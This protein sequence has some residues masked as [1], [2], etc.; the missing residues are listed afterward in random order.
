MKSKYLDGN[1]GVAQ[2]QKRLLS[3]GGV[4]R[5]SAVAESL[6]DISVSKQEFTEGLK[7]LSYL[8]RAQKERPAAAL[9]LVLF[10]AKPMK[11]INQIRR[12]GMFRASKYEFESATLRAC[13]SC[14]AETQICTDRDSYPAIYIQSVDNLLSLTRAV[15]AVHLS[16]KKE[17]ANRSK[18]ALKSILLL[19]DMAL[20]QYEDYDAEYCLADEIPERVIEAASYLLNLIKGPN[21]FRPA[22]VFDIDDNV[23]EKGNIYE[24]LVRSAMRVVDYR[25]AETLLDGLPYHARANGSTVIVAALDADIEKSVRVGYTQH[26]VQKLIRIGAWSGQDSHSKGITLKEFVNKTFAGG[27]ENLM[28]LHSVPKERIVFAIPAETEAFSF[29]FQEVG[30]FS[31][32]VLG[33]LVLEVDHWGKAVGEAIKVSDNLDSFDIFKVQ[34]IFRLVHYV[35]H[36]KLSTIADPARRRRLTARSAIPVLKREQ[37]LALMELAIP[38]KS[39]ECLDLLSLTNDRLYVD[40]QYTPFVRVGGGYLI[41]PFIVAGSNLVRNVVYINRLHD[42]VKPPEDPMTRLVAEHLKRREF[43]VVSELERKIDGKLVEF[44]ILAYREG[45]ML[46]FECKNSFFPCS[47]HEMRTSWDHVESAARQLSERCALLGNAAYQKLVVSSLGWHGVSVSQLY[48]AIIT[49]N[50]IFHG[51][52]IEGH[53]VRQARELI[54]VLDKGEIRLGDEVRRLWRSSTFSVEDLVIYL[55]DQNSIARAQLGAMEMYRRRTV[56]GSRSLEFETYRVQTDKQQEIYR[57]LY[58]LKAE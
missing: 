40:L 27:L 43:L 58:D 57:S 55:S 50:R 6:T 12:E 39:M 13:V 45:T 46:V 32:E 15:K 31:E 51:L 52:K 10:K 3:A 54:N 2:A 49:G 14:I 38:G 22:P 30:F 33:D 18:T 11:F 1:T 29:L 26:F 47:A 7:H 34:R 17:L 42:K 37:L 56:F 28:L 41:P 9:A 8:I 20:Q 25:E 53:P 23:L 21:G 36:K 24:M 4:D 48:S 16:L 19:A 44:D 35:F 5:M